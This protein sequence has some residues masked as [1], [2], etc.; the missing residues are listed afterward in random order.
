MLMISSSDRKLL[1]AMKRAGVVTKGVYF[2]GWIV[3]HRWQNIGQ[4][5]GLAIAMADAACDA[6]NTAFKGRA[7][8]WVNHWWS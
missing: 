5:A 3:E 2:S 4:E 8:V 1:N 6:L 7:F